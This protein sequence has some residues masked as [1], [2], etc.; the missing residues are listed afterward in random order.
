[1]GNR[2]VVVLSG[3]FASMAL[4]V[5]ACGGN[6]AAKEAK[7]LEQTAATKIEAGDL[8]GAVAAYT[9]AIAANPASDTA[10]E[11]RGNT[12]ASQQEYDLA[13]AD[14]TK[15]I[16]LAPDRGGPY[17]GRGIAYRLQG[18]LD[19]AIADLS[20]A[21]GDRS[22]TRWRAALY[23]RGLAYREKGNRTEARADFEQ[24]LTLERE[25]P[26]EADA[27][28]AVKARQELDRMGP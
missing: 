18:N 21:I 2:R 8:N 19:A 10:Y 12:Y 1:M 13:I 17:Y 16:E 4:A 24:I 25:R 14:L 26:G 7:G 22:K 3:I 27:S 23:E 6:P 5:S 20:Q 15:A 9:Q 11:G 28:W